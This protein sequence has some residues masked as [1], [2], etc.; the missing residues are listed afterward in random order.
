MVPSGAMRT[1][2]VTWALASVFARASETR[3][4]PSLPSAR[5]NVMPPNPASMPRREMSVSIVVMSGLP[6]GALDGGDDAVVGAAAADVAVHV[7]D[8]LGPAR[9]GIG[10]E[11]LGRLH[12]LARL[13]VAALRH[14]LGD[15][16]LLQR[17]RR[18][19]RQALDGDRR[20]AFG[21]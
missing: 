9:P 18:I 15:P 2:G 19:V 1:H 7:L 17:M 16:R 12:D 6:A 20:P 10:L 21:R 5:Q 13:A 11:E 14:L 4:A 3:R 8:D